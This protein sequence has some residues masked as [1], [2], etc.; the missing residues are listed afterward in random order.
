MVHTNS[1]E[2]GLPEFIQFNTL[3]KG[4]LIAEYLVANGVKD[5]QISIESMANNFPLA[6]QDSTNP[7]SD[8]LHQNKR[9][10]FEIVNGNNELLIGAVRDSMITGTKTINKK[11]DFFNAIRKGLYYSVEFASSDRM[12]KNAVLRLY[13]GIYIRKESPSSQNKYYVGL[14]KTFAEA[15]KQQLSLAN[16]SAPY[17][18]VIPFLAGSIITEE[19]LEKVALRVPDLKNFLSNQ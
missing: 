8:Y 4:D 19:E 3:S 6:E 10:E 12:Y 5:H 7:D 2:P 13:D 16:S 11:A 17:S 15:Q 18:K 1:K 14:Y 9:I